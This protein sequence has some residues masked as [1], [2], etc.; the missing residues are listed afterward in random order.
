MSRRELEQRQCIGHD[1]APALPHAE[2]DAAFF[3]DA[4]GQAG[5][6]MVIDPEEAI[7]DLA[8]T[9]ERTKIAAQMGLKAI[10]MGGST[11]SGEAE[12]VVPHIRTAIDEAGAETV[13][14]GFPGSSRQI[15]AGIDCTLLLDLPQIY[16]VFA[17]NPQLEQYLRAQQAGIIQKTQALGVPLV[18]VKYILFSA[19]E[20][21]SVEKATRINGIKVG[22]EMN[23]DAIMQTLEPW[24]HPGDQVFLELGSAPDSSVNL[25]PIA[26]R[27]F[28]LTGV[29]PIIS[30]GIAGPDNVRVVTQDHPYPVGFGSL[31]E[32]TPADSFAAVYRSLREAHPLTNG[33]E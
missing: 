13:I 21:T 24:C 5:P 16:E 14:L 27:V 2:R 22:P 1:V 29:I 23:V 30:G 10:L 31:A 17:G 28:A 9:V 11:D 20:P 18:P 25:A 19:G 33:L 8:E 7:D 6:I 3:I 12:V 4:I 26:E 32:K 15:V